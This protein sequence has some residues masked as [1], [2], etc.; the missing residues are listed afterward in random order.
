MTSFHRRL[1]ALFSFI[2]PCSQGH[3]FNTYHEAMHEQ[4]TKRP[5]ICYLKKKIKIIEFHDHIWN[6]RVKYIQLSTNM[7]S[8]G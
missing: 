2:H 1:R 3:P 7:S 4:T 8:I 5:Q 6:H